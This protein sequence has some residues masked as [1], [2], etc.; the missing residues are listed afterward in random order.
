[1]GGSLGHP[2][3]LRKFN[4]AHGGALPDE[5]RFLG[6]GLKTTDRIREPKE[7]I[8]IYFNSLRQT[9]PSLI[10]DISKNPGK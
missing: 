10:R 4:H 2:P 8:S 1:L 9:S 7:R 3:P 6:W 5:K